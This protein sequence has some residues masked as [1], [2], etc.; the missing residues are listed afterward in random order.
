MPWIIS[1]ASSSITISRSTRWMNRSL[2][3]VTW[4]R[5]VSRAAPTK[6]KG[7]PRRRGSRS[8]KWRRVGHAARRV[9]RHT[10][11]GG[12]Q[13]SGLVRSRRGRRLHDHRRGAERAGGFCGPSRADS[14]GERPLQNRVRERQARGNLGLPVPE[15]RYS[16]GKAVDVHKREQWA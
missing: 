7:M 2:S 10:G 14:A 16:K 5:T 8:G 1:A 12:R 13:D 3:W 4:A 11:A 15:N 6:S 9:Y